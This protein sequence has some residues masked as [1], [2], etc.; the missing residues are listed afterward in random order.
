M[1]HYSKSLISLL[2]I[3]VMCLSCFSFSVFAEEDEAL[4]PASTLETIVNPTS[5]NQIYYSS[6][7]YTG[8]RAK[9]TWNKV[10]NPDGLA[11]KYAIRCWYSGTTYETGKSS[12]LVTGLNTN[13]YTMTK[14]LNSGLYPYRY[15]VVSYLEDETPDWTIA[16]TQTLNCPTEAIVPAATVT[17]AKFTYSDKATNKKKLGEIKQKDNTVTIKW[18]VTDPSLYS[19][20]EVCRQTEKGTIVNVGTTTATSKT[21]YSR[22]VYATEGVSKFFIRAYGVNPACQSVFVQSSKFEGPDVLDNLLTA[23]VDDVKS[24]LSWKAIAQKKITLYKSPGGDAVTTV[25]KNTE[26][27]A[28]FGY[29]PETFSFWEEPTWV[30]VKYDGKELWAKWSQVKMKWVISHKDYA[31]SVKEAFVKAEKCKSKTSY[32]IWVSRYTQRTNVFHKENGKWKLIKVYDCN[33]GNYYQPLKGGQYYI[34]GHE[35]KKIKIHENGR[36]YYFLNSTKFGGSGTFHTRCRWVDTGN[37]RN[38]IKR[39][40]TTKGCCRLYDAAAKYVYNLP[41]GTGVYIH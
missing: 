24:N 12:F 23:G 8:N 38:A 7:D 36:E 26:L 40:P 21:S 22:K 16:T 28:T 18:Q 2:L 35:A 11:V 39:H 3:V 19:R 37:L 34:N 29:S 15:Q 10:V 27:K 9:F 31:W 13:V 1:K 20:F 41:S 6:V 32:L 25:P 4:T 17:S 14:G 30:E 33:T 5:S